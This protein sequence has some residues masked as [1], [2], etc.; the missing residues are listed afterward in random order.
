MQFNRDS[1]G[2]W[3]QGM[4]PL[5]NL[6]QPVQE[7]IQR[8]QSL[9]T[10]FGSQDYCATDDCTS[11][12]SPAAY[13]CDLLLW[14]R[15][16]PQGGQTSLDVLD[17]RR[18]DIR[19]LLLNCPNTDTQLPYID[20]V[21]ELLADKV[22]PPASTTLA[23]R[24]TA[25]QISITVTSAIGFPVPN[26]TVVIGMEILLVTAVG[27]ARGTRLG[28]LHE[29]SRVDGRS[30]LQR[31]C[32]HN[33]NT[34]QPAVEAD[35]GGSKRRSTERRTRVL[36][37]RRL[38]HSLQR[39]LSANVA[40]QCGIGRVANVSAAV[41]A[42]V[43]AIASVAAAGYRRNGRP[44][45]CGRRRA[46]RH[47]C[48]RRGSSRQSQLR[49][50]RDCLE[51]HRPPVPLVSVPAFLQGGS[52]SYESLLE[53]LEVTWVQ[54]RLNV[55]SKGVIDLDTCLRLQAKHDARRV[56]DCHT[57]LHHGYWRQRIPFT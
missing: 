2:V 55:A 9:A 54:G 11:I 48:A 45:G 26:F 1:I 6:N 27:G 28:P 50:G 21:I 56:Y 33:N 8:D 47:E 52:I 37:P 36:Q 44:A 10:L 38:C 41:E 32:S 13:L 4:G 23:V 49:L 35:L 12:L 16:H 20:L 25:T 39:E 5:S 42:P 15:N 14:L 43:L 22:S 19:H 29:D 30:C 18:P 34:S 7:A 24:I 51:Y 57:D 46:F 3:P 40:L 53:L 31:R 17:S